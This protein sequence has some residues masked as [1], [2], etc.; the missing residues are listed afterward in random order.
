MDQIFI[1]NKTAMPFWC[2]IKIILNGINALR[3]RQNS[4]HSADD[5]FKIIFVNENV[6]ITINISL[7]FIPNGRIDNMPA[8]AQIMAWCQTVHKP[9]SEPMLA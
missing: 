8:L 9:L 6:W 4:R 7:K 1:A 5:I 2:D 3:P